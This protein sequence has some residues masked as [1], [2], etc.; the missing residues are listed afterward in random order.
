MIQLQPTDPMNT[1]IPFLR[2]FMCFTAFVFANASAFGEDEKKADPIPEAEKALK[3]MQTQAKLAEYKTSVMV[4]SSKEQSQSKRVRL[5]SQ[6]S[7]TLRDLLS[8]DYDPNY[9]APTSTP[10]ADP[11]RSSGSDP[12][13]IADPALRQKALD[14][15][16]ALLAK[17]EKHNFQRA[18]RREIESIR[19][20]VFAE[21]EMTSEVSE[22]TTL[23]NLQDAGLTREEAARLLSDVNPSPPAE[24]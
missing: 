8:D 7:D 4:A 13:Q 15:R 16:N 23:K 2:Y 17:I 3:G 9:I 24:K 19:R 22:Q 20:L 12:N 18:L 5:L 14:E 11:K 1:S 6:A 21:L 10:L